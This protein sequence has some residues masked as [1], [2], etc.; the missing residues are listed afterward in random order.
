M[1][2]KNKLHTKLFN[3]YYQLGAN[4]FERLPKTRVDLDYFVY[5]ETVPRMNPILNKGQYVPKEE[6]AALRECCQ[7]G[8]LFVSREDRDVY[9]RYIVHQLDLLLM[10]D[11]LLEREIIDIFISAFTH[12]LEQFFLQP[13]QE[14]LNLLREDIGVLV[15][16]LQQD[17]YRIKGLIRR[18]DYRHTL[19]TH[20]INVMLLGLL[21]YM[22]KRKNACPRQEMQDIAEGLLLHDLGMTKIPGFV[23]EK[24]GPLQHMEMES[25]RQHP[26]IGLKLLK[27]LGVDSPITLHCVVDHHERLDGSG[28][29]RKLHA[30]QL[31]L[32]ARVA[33]VA[34]SFAAMISKRCHC[35]AK[36]VDESAHALARDTARYDEK[37]SKSLL[38]YLLTGK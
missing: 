17:H 19:L 23:L 26:V 22:R 20:S 7:L 34:D 18:L 3:E 6:H 31:G 5:D 33:A 35:H 1:H 15:E 11:N 4:I 12:R 9:M 27:R 16:Y 14:N 21:L 24:E 30:N 28:Y 13:L 2:S 25:V 38:T 36:R 8:T 37:I 32:A 29:P 10:D